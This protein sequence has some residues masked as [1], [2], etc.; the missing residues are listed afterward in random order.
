MDERHADPCSSLRTGAPSPRL[1]QVATPNLRANLPTPV[2]CR[3]RTYYA[4]LQD[5]CARWTSIG[6]MEP[7]HSTEPA[8][9]C[10]VGV[11]DKIVNV[12]AACVGC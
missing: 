9:N 7:H 6:Q 4:T 12:A 11:D 10:N 5:A 2:L 1:Q 8:Q 3:R